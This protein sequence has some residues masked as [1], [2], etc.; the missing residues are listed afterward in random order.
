MEICDNH[1]EF[2]VGPTLNVIAAKSKC[3]LETHLG[4]VNPVHTL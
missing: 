3:M 2:V 4:N 1:L